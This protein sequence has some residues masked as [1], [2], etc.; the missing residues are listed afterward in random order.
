MEKGKKGRSHGKGAQGTTF[1]FDMIT[2]SS[3]S[4]PER[5]ED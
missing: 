5:G 2:A 3:N 4:L 1:T